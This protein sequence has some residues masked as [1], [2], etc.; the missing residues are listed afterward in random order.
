MW[1]D[2]EI[3]NAVADETLAVP[4][5]GRLFFLAHRPIVI[6][7]LALMLQFERPMKEL[8]ANGFLGLDN[9]CAGV[10]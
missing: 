7:C 3:P 1:I 9:R 10:L 6:I 5:P 4:I 2:A 8:E